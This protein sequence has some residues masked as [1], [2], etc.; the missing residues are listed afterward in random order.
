LHILLII[1]PTAVKIYVAR[2][3]FLATLMNKLFWF[4]F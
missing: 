2:N 1:S 4:L 3:D